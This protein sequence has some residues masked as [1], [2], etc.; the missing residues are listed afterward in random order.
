MYRISVPISMET[1]NEE[2][3][4]RFGELLQAMGAKRVFLC[5]VGEVYL[6]DSMLN[7][8]PAPIARA[9]EYFRSLGMEV[10]I[11]VNAFG[12]GELLA[13]QTEKDIG[14]FTPIEDAFG[15][16]AP[17]AF[18]PL[19]ESFS[20]LYAEGIR[21]LAKLKPD[22]IML[23]DDLRFNFRRKYFSIGCFCPKHLKQYYALLGEELPREQIEAKIFTGAP[24]KYRDAYMTMMHR[25]YL[26]F[27]HMLRKTVDEVDPTIRLGA[28]ICTAMWDSS[29][30]DPIELAKAFAGKTRPFTR[31]AGA[32][33]HNVNIIPIIER[34]R[35]Q[36]AWA[37]GSGVEIFCEGDTYPRPRCNVPSRPL[38]LFDLAM[39][40]DSTAD[41]MLQY[42]FDYTHSLS[43]EEGYAKRII[44]NLPL[45]QKAAAMFAGKKAQGVQVFD[46]PHKLKTWPLPA[47]HSE[48]TIRWLQATPSKGM[49]A[50]VLGRNAIPT[51]YADCG[52]PVLLL[53]EN[54]RHIDLS[55]LHHGALLDVDAA[56]ILQQRGVDVGLLAVEAGQPGADEHFLAEN[57]TVRGV[58]R[59]G[60]VIIR[61]AGKAESVFTG[62]SVASY[63]YE[64][65][66][67]QRF[68]V[69]A[70]RYYSPGCTFTGN[71]LNSW[72]RRRQLAD[73][74]PWLCGK[75][76]PA[77]LE[78]AP[79]T[80]LLVARD[81]K[82]MAVA[83][84]N[85]S[86]DE[87]IDPVIHLDS[88]YTQI[89]CANCTGTVEGT[90]V[91]LSTIPP[92][93]FAAFE[94]T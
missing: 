67:G 23:D 60:K 65:A 15:R 57:E 8:D 76:L 25:T 54:A 80:Q 18:C 68:F 2:S 7:T 74:I 22:L 12:H 83:V 3:L 90:T 39:A 29:G 86:Y 61:T 64:N 52:Y 13:H 34:S 85:L 5:C 48:D 63:R 20:R 70:C 30:T 26:D 21:T 27:A 81:E 32:P 88:A 53:G 59:S 92:F 73:V 38:E 79:E 35:Q 49:A 10:G 84:L 14:H 75:Q 44:R 62:Q 55:L 17:V 33:Y 6:P 24:G 51:A 4:P 87:I 36:C 11:W 40:C 43:Y 1:V 42:V 72:A 28:S 19:D 45:R 9:M 46:V 71:Y 31:I 41:G 69:Q 66:D 50:D 82:A 47:E 58:G 94:L 89:S 91:R 37:K 93:G 78:D 16:S 56:E 77:R